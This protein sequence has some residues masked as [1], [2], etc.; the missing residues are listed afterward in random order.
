MRT[1]LPILFVILV[2]SLFFAHRPGVMAQR[3]TRGQ[4]KAIRNYIVYYGIGR[5]DDLARYDLVIIQPDTLTQ[6]ELTQL[7]A[8]GTL[9]VAYLSIGEVEPVRPW[10]FDG[11][12]EQ[13]WILGKNETWGSYYVDA[14]QPGWQKLIISLAKEYIAK[15]YNGLFLDNAD[16]I[17]L[18]PNT[19]PGFINLVRTLRASLP[20]VVLIQNRG[21]GILDHVTAD[22]DALMIESLSS[23]YDFQKKQYAYVDNT[24]LAQQ[25]FQLHQRTGLTIL[26]LDYA[27]PDN[28]IMAR[29]AVQK[30]RRLGFISAV[31]VIHLTD[32]PTYDGLCPDP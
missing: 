16:T 18:F 12:V 31:S 8:S 21:I 11:R 6:P 9:T 10:Y 25:I 5:L 29:L 20:Q 24:S 3:N 13:R 22:I 14:G 7:R 27:P 32:I 19:R 17:N 26:V 30:A 15:G 28:P 23:T 2:S 4:I 1:K